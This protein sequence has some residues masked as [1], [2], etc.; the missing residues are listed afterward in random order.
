MNPT[1]ETLI[2]RRSVRAYDGRQPDDTTLDLI[3]EAGLYAASGMNCQATKLVVCKDI[4][5]VEYM[6]KLNAAL[7]GTDSDPF[8]GAKTV[9]VVFA[10]RSRFT[11]VEDGSLVMGNLMNAA[12]SLGVD[13]C[14][15]HRAKE[16]FES[17]QGRAL[18]A[19]WG[20]GD[21]YMGVGNCILG[22][23]SGDYPEAKER[24]A[25]RVIKI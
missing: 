22:Y 18:K 25:D 12:H 4:E 24:K 7:L 13:S 19:E 9:I 20:I 11:A 16:V 23:R 3:V 15:I 2:T 6:S 14:W 8:Y 1:I 5:T 21:E 10:D 17:E